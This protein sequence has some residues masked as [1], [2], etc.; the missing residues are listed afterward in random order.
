VDGFEAE[1]LA[2]DYLQRKNHTI[3][4]HNYRVPQGEV[5]IVSKYKNTLV[6]IEVKFLKN[7]YQYYPEEQVTKSKQNKILKAA[8]S[9]IQC[10][11]YTGECR[12]DVLAIHG[13]KDTLRYDHFVDAFEFNI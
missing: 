7:T 1:K 2:A 4:M 12:F 10:Y 6:F 8:N 13:E 11:K 5:D 3:L 9:Y